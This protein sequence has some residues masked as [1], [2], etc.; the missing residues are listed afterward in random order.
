MFSS[1]HQLATAYS[2]I[3][4]GRRWDSYYK[5][6]FCSESRGRLKRQGPHQAVRMHVGCACV[7]A[8][9]AHVSCVTW[10]HRHVGESSAMCLEEI[11]K[12]PAPSHGAPRELLAQTFCCIHPAGRQPFA[13]ARCNPAILGTQ[14]KTGVANRGIHVRPQTKSL[15]HDSDILSPAYPSI[16]PS[17]L[18]RDVPEAS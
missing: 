13:R 1:A 11:V 16:Y 15:L 18:I 8:G 5:Q 10:T 14:S 6:L 2:G 17:D 7:C 3:A 4:G 12:R 9:V